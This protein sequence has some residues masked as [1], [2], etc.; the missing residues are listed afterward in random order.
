MEEP[1]FSK[2]DEEGE[3]EEIG[4][5]VVGDGKLEQIRGPSKTKK[6][7]FNIIFGVTQLIPCHPSMCIN[8]SSPLLSCS[9]ARRYSLSCPPYTVASWLSSLQQHYVKTTP[10]NQGHC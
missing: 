7:K 6:T 2:G 1:C 8:S 5:H 4:M 3:E 10:L 9:P